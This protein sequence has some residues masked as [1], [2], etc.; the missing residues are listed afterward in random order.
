[1]VQKKAAEDRRRGLYRFPGHLDHLGAD[2]YAG[3]VLLQYLRQ[4]KA[5]CPENVDIGALLQFS[6]AARA[7]AGK[8]I[9]AYHDFWLRELDF[10][11][12]EGFFAS[13][14][15]GTKTCDYAFFPGCQLGAF[16]PGHVL[17]SYDY[18][19]C[20]CNAG[21]ILACCGAPAY[22]AGDEKRLNEN[23]AR[24][25]KTWEGMGNPTLVFACATCENMFAQFMPDIK[26]VSLYELLAA[27][28]AV[29]PVRPFPEAAVFDPCAARDI[30]AMQHGVRQLAQKAGVTLRELANP[31]RCCGYGGHIRVANPGLYDEITAN[32]AK[33]SDLPYIAYC[34]NCR[35]VFVHKNK[36]CV[37]ILDMVFTPDAGA[38]VPGLQQKRRNSLE[39]K[40]TVMKDHW[41]MDFKPETRDWDAL[42]LVMDE[43]L[44]EDLDRKLI[45]EDDL[46]EAIWL[47]ETSGD[48]FVCDSDGRYSAAWRSPF[49]PTGYSIGRYRREPFGFCRRS[50]IACAS[51]RRT[52]A[53]DADEKT[54]KCGK[55]GL[56]LA[57]KKATFSYLGHTF[58][59]EV[60]RCPKCGKVFIPKSLAEGKMAEVESQLEDK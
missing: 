24:L 54:W 42:E 8:D 5:V 50:A 56:E 59:H 48:R 26:R 37:H 44:R 39:V 2:N 49:S 22:W 6:R 40:K 30:G 18:L 17:K 32:R 33:A 53:M 15:Q 31:N 45:M 7:N 43:D 29:A 23:K 13:A 60:M 21:L 20:K 47:A 12:T 27:D 34:A 58:A 11:A 52:D 14:P 46:K 4:C 38:R 51:T 41:G 9:P 57:K 28:N 35:D 55:C 19:K 1:M 3:D 16:N 36:D 25:A 10:N